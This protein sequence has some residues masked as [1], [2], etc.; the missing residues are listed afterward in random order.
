M[1]D[2]EIVVEP[3]RQDIVVVRVFDAPRQVVFDAYTDPALIPKWWGGSRYT[4]EVDRMEVQVGGQWR[5]RTVK[6]DGTSYGFRGVY[7]DVVSPQRI[8]STFEFEPGGPGYVQ[9]VTVSFDELDGQTRLTQ[10]SLFE[11]IDD[12]DGWIPTGMD[13]GIRESMALL[14]DV[15]HG[16]YSR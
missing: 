13:E 7:H 16:R 4:T 8:V 6:A 10:V 12:R 11:S 1:A 14:A 15:V 2:T 3:G 5:F 9:L